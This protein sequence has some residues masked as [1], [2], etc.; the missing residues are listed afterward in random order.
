MTGAGAPGGPGI[1]EALLSY[2]G[3]ELTIADANPYASGRALHIDFQVIPPAN[4]PDFIEAIL[5]ICVQK[6]I[7]ILLPL[8]TRELQLLAEHK[9]RFSEAGIRIVVAEANLLNIANDKRLLMQHLQSEGIAT[10]A[11]KV[12]N[13]AAQLADCVL[14]LGYPSKPVVIKPSVSNGSRGM[15]VLTTG[16]NQL[17]AFFNQKPGTPVCTLEEVL[18]IFNNQEIPEML[19]MEYLPGDEYSVD[20]LLDHG[21]DMLILPRK[22]IKM[23]A[24]ISVAGEFENNSEIIAYTRSVF[25]ALPLHG[26]IG[27][28][29]KQNDK[30]EFRIL[31]INPRLQ[32]STTTALGMGI[33]IPVLS[34]LQAAELEFED[35]IAKPV[36]GLKFVR[37]YKDAFFTG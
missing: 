26:P 11:F 35:L 18:Q 25:K 34:V 19:V 1:I 16:N 33:N 37:Y 8:V 5:A 23:N 30:G 7:H 24:G 29:V 27:L 4:S 31:E 21:R 13:T 15:R 12:A 6:Q 9:Q 22:R 10:A 32:G 14:D 17:D 2:S 3:I 20:C 28:Q 36:W